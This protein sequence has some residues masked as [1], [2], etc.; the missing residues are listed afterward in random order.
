MRNTGLRRQI[1]TVSRGWIVIVVI[2]VL[3]VGLSSQA[4]GQ[5]SRD[6]GTAGQDGVDLGV[7]PR[8]GFNEDTISIDGVPWS[9]PSAQEGIV[10][11]RVIV[12]FKPTASGTMRAAVAQSLGSSISPRR[13]G[14]DFDVISIPTGAE[15][16]EVVRQL[17]TRSEVEYAEPIY[18]LKPLH[19]PNDAQYSRQWNFPAIHLDRAW[20]INRG[21]S[22]AVIVAVL[23]TG[24]AYRNATLNVT[25]VPLIIG[26]RLVRLSAT[27]PFAAAPDLITPERIV[28]P[29]DFVWEDTSPMDTGSH[30]T[31]V[32]GTIGQLTDNGV[33]VAGI[34]S[35]V[36]LMPLKVLDTQWDQVFG[37]PNGGTND[38]LA[39][40]IRYAADH[41]A[42]VINMSLG[43]SSPI[44]SRVIEDALRYAVSRGVFVAIA[45]GNEYL[46]GNPISQ[47]AALAPTIPG[48]MAV[49]AVDRQLRRAWYSNV[50]SYVEVV[51][52]GGDTNV[53]DDGGIL[54]QTYAAGFTERFPPRFD[55]FQYRDLQGTSM[56]SPHVAGVAALLYSQG[57][58][59]PAAIEA[60]IKRF[61]KDLGTPG[62]DNEYG[63]GLIDARA[64]LLGLGVAR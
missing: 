10:R 42:N 55:M 7:G 61:A 57:I 40:A 39:R 20:D 6:I 37:A 17:L 28:S 35:Q 58:T 23:D 41:G 53:S 15:P 22:S 33:G 16:T 60:A 5:S 46:E 56:A 38:V 59:N 36:K 13:V 27:V 34:A 19:Q 43:Y 14:A 52:P 49:G 50:G 62:R 31:H 30:G 24:V 29:Y 63:Y 21:A 1:S 44:P 45:A 48:V 64:T 25:T 12:R 9:S 3:V 4:P 32:A 51:A 26:G 18:R 11:D 2:G 8:K 54:Q 47:P